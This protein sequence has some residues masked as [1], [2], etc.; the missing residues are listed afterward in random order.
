M[1][2]VLA[3]GTRR[4]CWGSSL[5]R[6]VGD[7]EDVAADSVMHQHKPDPASFPAAVRAAKAASSMAGPT[8]SDIVVAQVHDFFTGVDLISYED[9]GFAD[10]FGDYKPVEAEVTTVGGALPVNPSGGMKAKGHPRSA[11]GVAQCVELFQK[12][13][14]TAI[15]QV[16]GSRIA[17]AH[18]IGGPTAVSAV[19]LLEGPGTDGS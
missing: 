7:D 11:T 3:T 19:T 10:R 17:L 6:A 2:N 14:G 1:P 18:N 4:P 16:D 5:P 12:L 8:S 15:N 13:R 9:L